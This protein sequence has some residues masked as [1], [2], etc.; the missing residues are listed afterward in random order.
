MHDKELNEKKLYCI[1]NDLFWFSKPELLNDPYDCRPFF[2]SSLS[3][4]DIEHILDILEK[5]ELEFVLERF[6]WCNNKFDLI[7]LYGKII[8][9]NGADTAKNFANIMLQNLLWS[10]V[11]SKIANVGVLS[12]TG[13]YTNCLMWSH[14]AKN[15]QGVCLEIEIPEDTHSL[16]QV[17]YVKEQPVLAIYELMHEK[18]KKFHEI[19]YTKSMHWKYEDEW[20]MVSLLG[21][22]E[23]EIPETKIKKIIFGIN[24]SDQTKKKISDTV[25]KDIVTHQ[26]KMKRNYKLE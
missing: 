18:Y 6:P 12:L 4:T 15:N 1:K 11:K 25:G 24:T 10:I 26:I 17:T 13:V 9:S 2:N 14:Y 22:K 23:K 20:R 7:K 3:I 16:E 8:S 19:F 5:D 21:N